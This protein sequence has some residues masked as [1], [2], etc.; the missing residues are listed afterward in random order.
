MHRSKKMGL[1]LLFLKGGWVAAV[2][3]A[4]LD[5]WLDHY[6]VERNA[7][8]AFYMQLAKRL[9]FLS[10]NNSPLPYI[11]LIF[12]LSQSTF[13]KLLCV[14]DD[15]D[16]L[17]IGRRGLEGLLARMLALIRTREGAETTRHGTWVFFFCFDCGSLHC[18]FSMSRFCHHTKFLLS[19]RWMAFLV[20]CV[21]LFVFFCCFGCFVGSVSECVEWFP[22]LVWFYGVFWLQYI[23][24]GIDM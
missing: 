21:C 14:V 3:K 16:I 18:W 13:S 22:L 24:V 11:S 17:S 5:C 19:I 6:N 1:V 10:S 23:H 2:Y 12:S 7:A 9:L 8:Q 20:V 4:I 15:V